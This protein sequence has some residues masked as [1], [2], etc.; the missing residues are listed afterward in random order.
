[1]FPY[2]IL[3]HKLITSYTIMVI[4]GILITG[5]FCL[6]QAK[7]YQIDD[8]QVIWLLLSIA[9]GIL[10]GGHLLYGITNLKILVHLLTHLHK[11]TSVSMLFQ[12]IQEIFG[13]S[14]FYGGLYGGLL[15]GYIYSRNKF[16]FSKDINHFIPAIPLFHFFGRIGCFLSGCCYGIKSHIGFVYQNA[17]VLEANGIRRFPVQLLEAFYNL[18]LFLILYYLQKK[19]KLKHSILP[20]YLFLYAIAR[21][22]FEFLRGD[23][24]RG[25]IGIF[26]TSQIISIIT[27][28]S[29]SCI[30]IKN[31][32]HK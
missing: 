16:D 24:Y 27:I 1:M 13:G 22:F 31:K 9:V 2:I 23:F 11:I 30:W 12:C 28:L 17:L 18:F 14:V 5:C 32:S 25:Y 15:A 3:F 20:L 19:G 26:S 8:N 10:I 21:F 6:K 7:K 4:I 29:I